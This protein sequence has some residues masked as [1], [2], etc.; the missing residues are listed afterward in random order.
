MMSSKHDDPCAKI[1]Q[2]QKRGQGWSEE[3][4][5]G[6]KLK[7]YTKIPVGKKKSERKQNMQKWKRESVG[8]QRELREWLV[9][10]LQ[11]CAHLAYHSTGP[12]RMPEQ[13]QNSLSRSKN[14]VMP[15]T[16]GYRKE[17]LYS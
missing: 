3:E 15:W 1:S 5:N 2:L 11:S 16:H 13:P 17:K 4:E 8:T 6:V 14:M 12:I 10:T 7:K 9:S